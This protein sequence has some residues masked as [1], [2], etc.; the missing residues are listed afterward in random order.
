MLRAHG[1][2]VWFLRGNEPH[3]VI[4][5]LLHVRLV[6]PV[7]RG[8][9]HHALQEFPGQS[10]ARPIDSSRNAF[11]EI[12]DVQIAVR[13]IELRRHDQGIEDPAGPPAV[14]RIAE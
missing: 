11:A 14:M 1:P 10:M 6:R 8:P 5:L 12:L 2:R 13:S 4:R 3:Q 9:R 7:F